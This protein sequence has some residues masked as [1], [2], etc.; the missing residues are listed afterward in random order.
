MHNKYPKISIITPSYN[1]GQYIEETI[2]SVLNQNYP[3]L[4][5][6]IID[7]GSTDN[8]VDIIKKYEDRL[9]FWVSESD[10]GQSHAINKGFKRATG[11]IITWL[12]SDDILEANALNTI[13]SA[14]NNHPEV[15][16]AYGL[17]I[18][19]EKE[20]LDIKRVFPTDDLKCRAVYSFPY[21]QPACFYRRHILD[22]IGYIDESIHFAMDHDL[23]LRI[24]INYPSV[25]TPTTLSRQRIHFET[26]TSQLID[27]QRKDTR[28]IVSTFY[29]SLPDSTTK[30]EC[31]KLLKTLYLWI[32]PQK[33][34]PIFKHYSAT[35]LNWILLNHTTWYIGQ[36]YN[37]GDFKIVENAFNYLD[38][39]F[40]N[41]DYK[42]V[43]LKT[44]RIRFKYLPKSLISYIR[45]LRLAINK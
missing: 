25:F 9:T 1:Q 4:E 19:F 10:N 7:G 42:K 41:L 16:F 6:I 15:Q 27:V 28:L 39:H 33:T 20:K 44:I 32:Q 34:Y 43:G 11:D 38:Q 37:N 29:N 2:L 22:T 18:D 3:N 31:I 23:F 24:V 12:N 5:Y 14:F 17:N 36:A 8:T 21:S 13:A 45:N 40:N 35:E 26:K 30:K